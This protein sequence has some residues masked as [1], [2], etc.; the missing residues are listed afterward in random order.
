MYNFISEWQEKLGV[1]I[2]CS[3]VGGG[4]GLRACHHQAY[5]HCD[6]PTCAVSIAHIACS[7]LEPHQ[8]HERDAHTKTCARSPL[9]THV[10][11]G[12]RSPARPQGRG[13]ATRNH[14][15]LHGHV[16]EKEPMGT[17]GPLALA[18]SLLDDGKGSP[19]FV[20][21]RCTGVG[22]GARVWGC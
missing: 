22:V 6:A 2:V 12:F 15:R 21:N 20:L 7:R 17:A 1:K 18:R 10:R 16:Q 3:Q 9:H 4:A 11:A 14:T 19:F 13:T 8:Q 5:M